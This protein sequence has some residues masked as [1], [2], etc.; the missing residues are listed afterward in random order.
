MSKNNKILITVGG[1]GG[2][3]F[4]GIYL[5]EHLSEKNFNVEIVTDARVYIFL[6]N[7]KS[8]KITTFPSLPLIKSNIFKFFYSSIFILYSIIRSI[9]FLI[10]NKPKIIF[11]MGGYASFPICIAATILR[12]KFILTHE[13]IFN[14]V[15]IYE[16]IKIIF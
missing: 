10:T 13:F 4:P 9:F 5:A 15:F 3:V 8:F 11:G 6:Q 1:T 2:H 14:S 7:N 16:L 12:I